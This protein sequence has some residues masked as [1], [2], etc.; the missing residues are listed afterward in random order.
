VEWQNHMRL[1]AAV[2]IGQPG[3]LLP[4]G[5]PS[6]G[7]EHPTCPRHGRPVL[8][9]SFWPTTAG[10]PG[11]RLCQLHP[12]SASRRGHHRSIHA[13]ERVASVC[14]IQP[15]QQRAARALQYPLEWRTCS[16]SD[17]QELCVLA[18]HAQARGRLQD[19]LPL[20]T[21]RGSAAS[22]AQPS[23]PCPGGHRRH[24]GHSTH[25]VHCHVQRRRC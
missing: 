11:P 22:T 3:Q 5:Q 15:H 14:A 12:H 23:R 16:A 7:L 10:T 25:S 20:H 6:C 4:D 2:A 9:K 1:P 24:S 17:L 19:C 13:S 18:V 8:H 21:G